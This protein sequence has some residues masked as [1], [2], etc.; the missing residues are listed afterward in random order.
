MATTMATKEE[1]AARL[2]RKGAHSGFSNEYCGFFNIKPGC[3][4]KMVKEITATLLARNPDVRQSY[5]DIDVFDARYCV[6]DNGTRLFLGIAFD[7]DF[8]T[9]FDD[10][11]M[12]ISGGKMGAG[13]T[14]SWFTN[15]EGSEDALTSWEATKNFLVKHQVDANI[16]A[17]TTNGTVKQVQ[18]ALDL[19][20][21]FQQVL[22]NPEAAKA[23]SHP[24]LKPLL[25]L[26][27][28]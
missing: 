18:K 26:A 24:A 23:L 28:G 14:A 10:A 8:D 27:A 25:D 1:L 5:F 17:N 15:L 12:L 22:D 20:K 13:T 6:F 4:E 7:K 9:Y 2:K 11:L 16:Y 3:A 19:Q 21:A